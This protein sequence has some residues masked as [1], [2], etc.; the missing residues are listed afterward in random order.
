MQLL[1]QVPFSVPDTLCISDSVKIVNHAREAETYY[2]NFCSGNLRMVPQGE[3]NGNQ[4]D[5]LDGPAFI[6]V[7]SDHG[8]F[9]SFVTNHSTGTI[10]RN[11][12]GESMLNKPQS[13]DLGNFDGRIPKHVEGIQVVK[14]NNEWFVFVVGG[15]AE[16]SRIVRISLGTS[17]ENNNPDCTNF[18][19]KG[20]LNYP[21]DLFLDYID[22]AWYGFTVNSANHTLTQ[23]IFNNG[24]S[25]TC[26]GKNLGNPFNLLHHPRGLYIIKT[27]SEW[28]LFVSNAREN[29][30]IR[31]D[32]SNS[33][34]NIAS[35]E[36]LDGQ[37]ELNFPFDITILSDCENFFGFVVNELSDELVLMDFGNDITSIPDY[38][39]QGNTGELRNPH[40]ISNVFRQGD[41]LYALI[42]NAGNSTLS[43]I[44][45]PVC[46]QATLPSYDQRTPPAY[47][48]TESGNYNIS[49]IID[50]GLPTQENYC[51]N[52]YAYDNPEVFIGNDTVLLEGT[53]IELSV[54]SSFNRITWST[55][56]SGQFATIN[57]EGVYF[58]TVE[59]QYGCTGSDTIIIEM[60]YGV[61][62]FFSPNGD[63][64]NDTWEINILQNYPE[65][66]ISIYDRFGK[67]LYSFRGGD[68]GW[69]GTYAGHAI[70]QGTYWYMIDFHGARKPITGH[71]TIVR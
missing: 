10:I 53:A 44:F 66:T 43:R 18:G 64:I 32:F 60:D 40:G 55:G 68:S 25:G 38:S 56:E 27:H 2:W 24:L 51:K 57:E 58:V 16:Q 62:N 29:T 71:L 20:D 42:A 31:L 17:I 37:D 23:F 70:Q 4:G 41:T 19:N 21:V 6:D 13:Y 7:V 46:S 45:Y 28:H 9:Y 39:I 35:G 69:D 22:N 12:F 59:D 11:K 3:N 63:G 49:L 5:L 47:T 52:I 65:A 26:A 50:E 14:E 36:K 1:A 30:I 67:L 61:P 15:L 54:D 48:Y 34:S 8:T 33:L